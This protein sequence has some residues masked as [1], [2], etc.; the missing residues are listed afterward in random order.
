M[1]HTIPSPSQ[2]IPN[3]STSL[4]S[5]VVALTAITVSSSSS[6]TLPAQDMPVV[7]S[8][9]SFSPS[10]P[11]LDR[12]IV[13]PP[14]PEVPPPFSSSQDLKTSLSDISQPVKDPT[15]Q[16]IPKNP[17]HSKQDDS[18]LITANFTPFSFKNS[19]IKSISTISIPSVSDDNEEA[20][21]RY[22]ILDTCTSDIDSAI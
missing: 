5:P 11:A 16:S 12:K 20:G 7:S 21:K 1:H 8:T 22:P 6:S 2:N 3:S 17:V 19:S 18:L 9:E 10:S 13:T 15:A 14:P 4:S